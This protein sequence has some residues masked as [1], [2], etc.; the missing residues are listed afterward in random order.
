[1][2]SDLLLHEEPLTTLIISQTSVFQGYYTILEVPKPLTNYKV[3]H[4]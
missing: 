4:C 1:M 3:V 2:D